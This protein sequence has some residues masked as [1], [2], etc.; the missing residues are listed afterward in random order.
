MILYVSMPQNPEKS[1]DVGERVDQKA[2]EKQEQHESPEIKEVVEGTEISEFID[3]EVSEDLSEG[4]KKVSS[5]APKSGKA[6]IADSSAADTS[7]PQLDVMRIQVATQVK[8]EIIDL[9]KQ[10][11][12]MMR[13]PTKFEPFHLNQVVSRIRNLK[14]IL[15][16]LAHSTTETVKMLWQKYIR[17]KAS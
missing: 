10:A 17:G 8:K 13:N 4:K 12:Q 9:E 14:D 6:A 11:S 1:R 16:N 5:G 15:A 7:L 3:G 2:L